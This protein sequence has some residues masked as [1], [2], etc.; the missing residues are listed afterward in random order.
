M[1][2]TYIVSRGNQEIGI[3]SA[4]N[5]EQAIKKADKTY[6]SWTHLSQ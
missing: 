2:K 6:P 1:D 3:V 5:R 4:L